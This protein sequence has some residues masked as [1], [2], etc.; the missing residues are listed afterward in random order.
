MRTAIELT[1]KLLEIRETVRR[2]HAERYPEV[3]GP[4]CDMV[5]NAAEARGIEP[6]KAGQAMAETAAE[7]HNGMG[8]LMVL[9]ATVE[10]IEPTS[11]ESNPFPEPQ[12][13]GEHG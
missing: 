8:A 3:I 1:G 13:R 2:L 6:L 10:I 5:R 12:E 7:G 11:T 4:W 9:A